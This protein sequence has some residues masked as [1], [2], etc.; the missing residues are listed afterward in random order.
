MKMKRNPNSQCGRQRLKKYLSY[1]F[2]KHKYDVMKRV[3]IDLCLLLPPLSSRV[4][5]SYI[6]FCSY[7]DINFF[8][9]R[10]FCSTF[11]S[12][13]TCLLFSSSHL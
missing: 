13:T 8:V 5:L 3:H 10:S 6:I 9:Y 4:V 1:I 12:T 2:K 7:C 11:I